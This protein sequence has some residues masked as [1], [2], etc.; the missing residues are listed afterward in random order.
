VS[1][2]NNYLGSMRLS[3]DELQETL[4]ERESRIAELSAINASLTTGK[5]DLASEYTA[6]KAEQKQL[7][8]QLELMERKMKI[9][10]DKLTTLSKQ[11]Q[12]LKEAT[13]QN[14]EKLEQLQSSLSEKDAAMANRDDEITQLQQSLDESTSRFAE[15]RSVA[16]NIARD[17]RARN[18]K[19]QFKEAEA[20]EKLEELKEISKERI[21][22]LEASFEETKASLQQEQMKVQSLQERLSSKEAE[23]DEAIGGL[24]ERLD[25]ELAGIK[26]QLADAKS[27]YEAEKAK[28]VALESTRKGSH[29]MIHDLEAILDKKE[30]LLE[31]R[32]GE[33]TTLKESLAESEARSSE[34]EENARKGDYSTELITEMKTRENHMKKSLADATQNTIKL[35]DMLLASGAFHGSIKGPSLTSPRGKPTPETMSNWGK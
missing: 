30:M 34:V 4:E 27:K 7:Q 22:Q 15:E 32:M 12:E 25:G 13:L 26:K 2:L 21:Q 6:S 35:K 33:I 28:V 31:R 18:E 5:D 17:L 9:E 8:E 23:R 14:T 29:K 16:M 19:L 10:N 3:V 20:Q 1:R 11:N 24:T